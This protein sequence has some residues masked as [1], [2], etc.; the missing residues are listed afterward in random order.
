MMSCLLICTVQNKDIDLFSAFHAKIRKV[1]TCVNRSDSCLRR[2]HFKQPTVVG[3]LHHSAKSI[4]ILLQNINNYWQLIWHNN[5]EDLIH[6]NS[7]YNFIFNKIDGIMRKLFK[8]CKGKAALLQAW[9]GPEGSRK[10][11]FP[12]FMT[13]AQDGKVVSLTHR[14]P[15]PPGNTPGTHFC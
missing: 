7:L 15:L 12:G 2:A 6:M 10:L 14:P 1:T 13:T 11:R 4:M 3:M 5:P 9:S 8:R